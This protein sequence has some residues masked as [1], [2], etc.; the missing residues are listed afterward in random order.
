MSEVVSFE[1]LTTFL[2]G[3]SLHEIYRVSVALF[4]ELEKPKRIA[5][6]KNSIKVGAVVDFFDGQ[7]NLTHRGEV[8]S[9]STKYASVMKVGTRGVW[10]IPYHM[11]VIDSREFDFSSKGK[12]LNKNQI[13]VGDIVGFN[14]DG[15]Q[16]TGQ[17]ERLNQKTV[18]LITNT[19]H[20]WRVAYG[21]LYSIID[22]EH[23]EGEKELTIEYNPNK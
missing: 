11:L 3:A 1:N 6:V 4:N 9:K 13:K 8:I 2:N 10:K 17:V 19:N 21:L 18:S 12:G 15:E 20:K 5:A 7:T 23:R 22:G 14:K 16:I